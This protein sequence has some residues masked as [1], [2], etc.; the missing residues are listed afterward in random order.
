MESQIQFDSSLIHEISPNT[1]EIPIGFIPDMKVPCYF[2]SS[3]DQYEFFLGELNT[4]KKDKSRGL[5]SLVMLATV[6]T[7]SGIS[8]GS[9]AMPDMH[10]GYGFTIGGVAAFDL[11]DPS[12]IISPGGVGNDINCG[13]R[14]LTTHLKVEQVEPVKEALISSIERNVPSGIGGGRKNFIKGL[15]DIDSIL[16]IL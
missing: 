8:K 2:Y 13:V 1:Y 5:P 10:S 4:W 3:P 11:D 16:A 9:F 14:C 7:L 6:S 15:K 12:A